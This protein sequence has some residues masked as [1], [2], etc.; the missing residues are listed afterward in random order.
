M[1][2][3]NRMDAHALAGTTFSKIRKAGMVSPWSRRGDGPTCRVGIGT[4]NP[5]AGSLA[6][7]VISHRGGFGELHPHPFPSELSAA[8]LFGKLHEIQGEDQT[9]CDD[10]PDSRAGNLRSVG[11]GQTG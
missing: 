4:K 6:A 2:S 10:K 9:G 5:A 8:A 11:D 1:S 7:G 3:V